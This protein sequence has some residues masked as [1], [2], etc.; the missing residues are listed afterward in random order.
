MVVFDLDGTLVD[1]LRDLAVST[2]VALKEQG[3]K[4]HNV[5]AYKYFVG[6]GVYKLIERALPEEARNKAQIQSTKEKFINYYDSHLTDY[7]HPYEGIIELLQRLHALGIQMAVVT[8]KPHAQ[9]L[10]VA[11]ACFEGNLFVQVEGQQ[12]GRAHKP[13]PAVLKALMAA[14]NVKDEEV[15]YVGDSDVDMQTAYNA[16][17]LG[18]GVAWGFRG[19]AELKAHGAHAVIH[20]PLQLLQH[21]TTK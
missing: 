16:G 14:Y 12:E 11:Q 2:N 1:T 8:N 9:A 5:E 15:V 19:E 7:T 3:Y 10:R 21:I 4:E 18:I 20:E 17:V 6:N 13:D